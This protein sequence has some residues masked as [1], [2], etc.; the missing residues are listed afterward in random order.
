MI[1]L[2]TTRNRPKWKAPAVWTAL[3]QAGYEVRMPSQGWFWVDAIEATE[4]VT[5][6]AARH[7]LTLSHASVREVCDGDERNLLRADAVVLD[8]TK[9][10]GDNPEANLMFGFAAA[11]GKQTYV[12]YDDTSPTLP[13]H[14]L[15][16]ERRRVYS[17]GDLLAA[18][19][20]DDLLP[21]GPAPAPRT[22]T[23][24]GDDFHS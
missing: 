1:Y 18:L 7:R 2:L 6:P 14:L 11:A 10:S 8:A 23:P 16:P 21:T 5:D 24:H 20:A 12:V 15:V 13:L 19:A 17:T 22:E 3:H 9:S 4:R